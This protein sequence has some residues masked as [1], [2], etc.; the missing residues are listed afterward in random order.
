[1]P[2]FQRDRFAL[3]RHPAQIAVDQP[4][5]GVG[6]FFR[7]V[8]D[9][10]YYYFAI[11]QGGNFGL[12]KKVENTWSTLI[13]WTP[14]SAIATDAVNRLGVW[15]EGSTIAL[16]VNDLPLAQVTDDAFA[17]GVIAVAA[18]TFAEPELT[19]VFDDVAVWGIGE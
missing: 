4:A 9:G 1:M 14:S 2:A 12:W 16:F 5:Q 13:D 10:N 8:D 7:K 19:A 17:S 15:A 11:E 18:G 6:V 3:H